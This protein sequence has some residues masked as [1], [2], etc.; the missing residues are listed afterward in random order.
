MSEEPDPD[1]GSG[2][3]PASNALAAARAALLGL[4]NRHYRQRGIGPDAYRV[5]PMVHPMAEGRFLSAAAA[6]AR[7][8]LITPARL[9]SMATTALARLERRKLPFGDGFGWG[10]GFSWKEARADEPYLITTAVVAQGLY[11]LAELLPELSPAQE[12]S[13]QALGALEG[14]SE[15]SA[16]PHPGLSCDLPAFSPAMRRPVVNAAAC[17]AAMLCRA[18]RD[19]SGTG[20]ERLLRI[21][22][23]CLPGIGWHY[24]PQVP[25]V[26]LLHQCY[27]LTALE[28]GI[29]EDPQNRRF[30]NRMLVETISVFSARPGE[31]F[32]TA[33]HEPDLPVLPPHPQAIW[34]FTPA[35]I[36]QVKPK[37]ARLWSLGELLAALADSIAAECNGGTTGWQAYAMPICEALLARLSESEGEALF[38][39]HLMHAAWGLA[40]L[41]EVVRAHRES[42]GV[43]AG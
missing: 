24:A 36:M 40:R 20:K 16:V 39:R 15:G 37:R 43:T 41:L 26:D 31:L 23:S 7:S 21:R 10:L 18:G 29:G 22:E 8:R 2:E 42:P 5:T 4:L 14:W 35:G 28:A 9:H 1:T 30:C 33:R 11:E 25:V 12:L 6:A 38:P 27:I 13:Q 17:A 32:D 19:L 3:L 34:R